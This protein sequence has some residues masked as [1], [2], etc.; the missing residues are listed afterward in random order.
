MKKILLDLFKDYSDSQD[1]TQPACVRTVTNSG[2]RY[3]DWDNHMSV[4]VQSTNEVPSELETYLSKPAI[5]RSEDFDI[6]VWWKSNALEFS[7]LSSMARDVLVAP[8]SSVASESAF[9]HGRRLI[10]DFRSRLTPKTV[11]ALM[12]LQD[13]FRASGIFIIS[14]FVPYSFQYD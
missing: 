12:C 14:H 5:P 9:S 4:S 10:S 6:L 8:A 11:E 13:W 7:T 2:S 3:D 1:T